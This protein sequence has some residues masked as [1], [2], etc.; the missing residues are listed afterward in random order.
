MYYDKWF[1]SS[2]NFL[3]EKTKVL[4]WLT[5]IKQNEF[6]WCDTFDNSIVTFMFAIEA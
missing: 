1:E 2:C 5:L 6:I 4:L 3:V